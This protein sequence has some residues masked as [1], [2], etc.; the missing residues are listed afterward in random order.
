MSGGAGKSVVATIRLLINAAAAKP[1]PPVGP[2]LGQA[3]LNIMAFCKE[4][5]ARTTGYKEGVPLRV[6]IQVYGDKS[7]DWMLKTPPSTWLIKQATGLI[8][9]AER[10]GQEVAATI[11][12]KH[13]YEIAR[14]KQQDNPDLDLQ[15]I[16]KSIMRTCKSMGV[17]VV[18]TPEDA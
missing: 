15:A 14:V 10:P 8:R 1:A 9:A 5:N 17:R 6:N 13:I 2:A 18:R 11:S 7:Y 3:G 4:F 16:C 12:L